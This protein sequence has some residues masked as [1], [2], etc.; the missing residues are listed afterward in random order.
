MKILQLGKAY[1]PANLGGVEVVIQLL[2]EG[3]N[4]EGEEYICD[5]L[6]VND[7]YNYKEDQYKN[8]II[9]R[10]KLIIKKFSTLFSLQLIIKLQ[11]ISKQYDIIHI[12]SPDPMSA[13]ALWLVNPNSKV[14]LHWHSDILRQKKL[15]FFYKPLLNWL[16]RK[17]ELILATSQNY[18]DGSEQLKGVIHKCKVLPIGI[19]VINDKPKTNLIINKFSIFEGKNIILSLGRLAY[20]KGFRYLVE[21]GKFLKENEIIVIAGDGEE[22]ELLLEIIKKEELE[23]KVFLVGKVSEEEKNYLFKNA[24][25]F[26]LS[27]IYKTEAYAIVQVE[28]LAYGL[29]I[30]ST[31]I[32]GS[33]VDFVNQNNVSGLVVPICDS[34]AISNAIYKILENEELYNSFSTNAMLRYEI[35]FTREKMIKKLLD[36]YNNLF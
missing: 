11:Q 17:S 6:G 31:K 13:L 26:V 2:T 28:A 3:L 21:C 7:S 33:G 22:K 23:N 18:I 32:E 24:K 20:Y 27:S 10:T 19:D 12:H 5:S 4:D 15:L 35:N 25:L 16:L 9:Y 14:V 36:Y 1:P 34:L 30:I 8:G 29:P